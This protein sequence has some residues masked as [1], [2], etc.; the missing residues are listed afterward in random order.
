M[1]P[2]TCVFPLVVKLPV[3]V[4]LPFCVIVPVTDTFLRYEVPV[5]TVKSFVTV[6]FCPISTLLFGMLIIPEP[7]ACS[8]RLS[9]PIV[10]AI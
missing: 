5:V 1:F 10:V 8:V 3:C 9:L 4:M 7:L 2:V 6:K